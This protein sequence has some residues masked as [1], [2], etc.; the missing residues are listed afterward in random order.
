M[1][2]TILRLAQ[3]GVFVALA[4]QLTFVILD[5]VSPEQASVLGTKMIHLISN[6]FS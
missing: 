4:I 2:T 1:K 6:K 5:L 3:A